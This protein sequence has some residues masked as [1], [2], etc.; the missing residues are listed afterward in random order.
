MNKNRLLVSVLMITYNHEKYIE[1]AIEGI[2]NQITDFN[3]ELIIT[4]DNSNYD[5]KKIVNQFKDTSDRVIIRCHENSINF[6]MAKNF[7]LAYSMAEA[8]YIA[9]CE[10]DDYW[11]DVNKLQKQVDFLNSRPKYQFC[12]T[13]FK[14]YRQDLNTFQEDVN[15]KYFFNEPFINIDFESLQSGWHMGTQTLLFRRESLDLDTIKSFSL[16]RDMHIITQLLKKGQG[17]CLSFFGAVYRIH[18]A[19]IH[20]TLNNYKKIELGYLV[21]K[22]IYEDNPSNKFLKE[23]YIRSFKD[24]V[25]SLIKSRR[26]LKAIN[27]SFK[28]LINNGDLVLFLKHIKRIVLKKLN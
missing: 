24:Y 22:E 23:R 17:A 28:L 26:L 12:F 10:G 15:G 20:S 25:I 8:K 18:D 27:M 13:R 3:Y 9:I 19:G 21:Y 11:T 4:D 2:V 1:Y 16:F 6:G 14:T 5:V 7:Q